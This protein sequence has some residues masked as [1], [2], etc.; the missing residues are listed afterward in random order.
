MRMPRKS[1]REVIVETADKL[2]Y[3]GGFAA[4]SFADIAAQVGISRG[5]FYHHFKTKDDILDA[6]I[7]R[8]LGDRRAMLDDWTCSSSDPRERIYAFVGIVIVNR[9]DIMES[10]CPVGTLASE[11]AKLDHG[12]RER[13]AAILDLFRRWLGE[14]FRLAGAERADELALHLL[15]WSQ[16]VAVL[17]SALRDEAYI[18]REVARI[19]AW[20]DAQLARPIGEE[21]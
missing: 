7:D 15:G 5:N 19:I 12:A 4:T 1:T 13:A 3:K 20:V 10:G 8:R 18:R 16:G 2:F 21:L 17:A 14:Q 6:V 9:S 11:L